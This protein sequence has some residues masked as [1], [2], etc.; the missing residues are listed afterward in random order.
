MTIK[1]V[2]EN[3]TPR[4]MPNGGFSELMEAVLARGAPFRFQASGFS[5]FPFIR[6][7]DLITIAP[8]PERIRSGEVVAFVNP[9]GAK[10]TVHRVVQVLRAGYL[11][12]GDNLP[13]PDGVVP[14]DDILGRVI[15]VE[16]CGQRMW[17]GLGFERAAIAFLSRR[18]WLIPLLAPVKS[19]FHYFKGVSHE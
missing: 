2:V 10:L 17:L 9:C 8:R 4:T 6:D 13:E 7:D 19:I 18:G 12:Q 16:H 14:H 11:L 15:R 3:E 1:Y 5:M